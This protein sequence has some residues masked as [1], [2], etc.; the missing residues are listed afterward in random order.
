MSLN[1]SICDA[2]RKLS[3]LRSQEQELA[4]AVLTFKQRYLQCYRKNFLYST[5]YDPQ[6]PE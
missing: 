2:D 6:F 5:N 1:F 3:Q 4:I